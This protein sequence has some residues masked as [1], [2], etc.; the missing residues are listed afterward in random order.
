MRPRSCSSVRDGCDALQLE[1]RLAQYGDRVAGLHVRSFGNAHFGEACSLRRAQPAPQRRLDGSR[2]GCPD[3]PGRHE[4]HECT[5]HHHSNGREREAGTS[6]GRQLLRDHRAS[7]AGHTMPHFGGNRDQQHQ[8]QEGSPETE[9]RQQQAGNE[10][11]DQRKHEGRVDAR[12]DGVRDENAALTIGDCGHGSIQPQYVAPDT[13]TQVGEGAVPQVCDL[14]A[15][16][17]MR[18]N[19]RAG[20]ADC[21]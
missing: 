4:G 6:P 9:T 16:P 19:H 1:L 14:Q 11:P 5:E 18:N 12:S 10:Q 13:C 3:R 8:E 17:S 15:S 2:S 20:S 21:N 7:E